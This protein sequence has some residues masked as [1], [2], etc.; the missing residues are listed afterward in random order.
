MKIV[1]V[2]PDGA[3]EAIPGLG[4][5]PKVEIDVA[6]VELGSRVFGLEGGGPLE[7]GQGFRPHLFFRIGPPQVELGIGVLGVDF[8]RPRPLFDRLVKLAHLLEDDAVVI[9]NVGPWRQFLQRLFEQRQGFAEKPHLGGDDGQQVY[10]LLVPGGVD[11]AAA[12]FRGLLQPV[13]LNEPLGGFQGNGRVHVNVSPPGD[14]DAP[15]DGPRGPS[16]R[17]MP[18]GQ[19][20]L[21]IL[22]QGAEFFLGGVT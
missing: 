13:G 14:P 12:G 1:R 15:V 20:R 5:A 17:S 21:G 4:L 6:E 9:E 10:R 22:G 19:R 8:D 16:V 3:G 7:R 18:L 11:E 2:Q